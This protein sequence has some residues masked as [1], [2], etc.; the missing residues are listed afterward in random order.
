MRVRKCKICGRELHIKEFIS[1]DDIC[2]TCNRIHF[3]GWNKDYIYTNGEN[4]IDLILQKL[5]GGDIY[6][7]GKK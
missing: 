4:K 1:Y 3:S 6:I 7:N 5:R 2:G